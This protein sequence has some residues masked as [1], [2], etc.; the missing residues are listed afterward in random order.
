MI[1]TMP[2]PTSLV[3]SYAQPNWLIDRKKL[4]GRF[5]PRVP[6]RELW[7]VSP[8]HLEEAQDDA[9]LIAIR[10]QECAGLDII[11]DGDAAKAILTGSPLH[12]KASTSIIRALRSTAPVILIPCRASSAKSAATAGPGPRCTIPTRE[13]G[14][15]HQGHGAWP[16]HHVTA[17]AERLLQERARD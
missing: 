1:N 6:A 10:D 7:L 9:T 12:S 2:L 4:A 8:E 17:G 5:P 15:H 3:G 16:I 13:H 14:P 11:T